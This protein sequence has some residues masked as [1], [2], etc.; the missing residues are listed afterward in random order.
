MP[1]TL[2]PGA[3]PPPVGYSYCDPSGPS[4]DGTSC[5]SWNDTKTA[6]HNEIFLEHWLQR[7]PSFANENEWYLIGESYAGIYVPTLV[8]QV[9]DNPSSNISA[10]LKGF[11]VGDGCV[12]T[13]VL[14]ANGQPSGPGPF[15]HLEVRR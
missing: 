3:S 15:F 12:G 6:I 2:L 8:R 4:G 13:D 14:C 11:A 10:R 1:L 9:L 5:G 7:F